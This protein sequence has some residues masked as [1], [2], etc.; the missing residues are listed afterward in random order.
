MTVV[1]IL[2]RV[3]CKLS[4]IKMLDTSSKIGAFVHTYNLVTSIYDTYNG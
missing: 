3:Y 4:V 1:K 2:L